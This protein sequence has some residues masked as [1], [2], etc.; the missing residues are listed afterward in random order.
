MSSLA[1]RMGLPFQ[2]FLSLIITQTFT[3]LVDNARKVA[4]KEADGRVKKVLWGYVGE[5]FA[6][7][8]CLALFGA[9]HPP[10]VGLLLLRRCLKSRH[11]VRLYESN[12]NRT[13]VISI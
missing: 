10:S 2:P 8:L 12:T 11:R 1:V 9:L 7:V 4:R 5:S 13:M 6:Y 3:G